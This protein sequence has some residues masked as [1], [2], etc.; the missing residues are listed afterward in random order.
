MTTRYATRLALALV[1]VALTI[2]SLSRSTALARIILPAA[3]NIVARGALSPDQISA[4]LAPVFHDEAF[5]RCRQR[6][7]YRGGLRPIW[8]AI[9]VSAAGR[10]ASFRLLRA[11]GG[12]AYGRCW[13]RA[14]RS[15]SFPSA[16]ETTTFV[17]DL[18]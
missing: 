12:E 18:Q 16:E 5:V 7:S 10:V 14:L 3:Q 17:V 8:A 6:V 13:S 15:V 2:P 4:S 11:G 1:L 9:E